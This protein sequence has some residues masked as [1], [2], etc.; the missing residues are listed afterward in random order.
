MYQSEPATFREG[1]PAFLE[2]LL[3]DQQRPIPNQNRMNASVAG[4][5][6]CIMR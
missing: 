6:A 1:S 4:V 2:Q 5:I 3:A